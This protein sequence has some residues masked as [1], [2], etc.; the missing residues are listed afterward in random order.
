LL[1]ALEE[2][3][4]EFLELTQDGRLEIGLDEPLGAAA[5]K[6]GRPEVLAH[7]PAGED[8]KLG[9]RLLELAAATPDY[10]L[11]FETSMIKGFLNLKTR[12]FSSPRRKWPC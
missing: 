2:R 3:L 8:A 7:D 1:L 11:L 5:A 6:K 10:D 12:V 4:V 9:A